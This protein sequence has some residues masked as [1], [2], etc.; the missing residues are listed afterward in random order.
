MQIV[1]LHLHLI[2]FG[3]YPPS[4]SRVITAAASRALF[5]REETESSVTAV[6]YFLNDNLLAKSLSVIAKSPAWLVGGAAYPFGALDEMDKNAIWW[7]GG[8][9]EGGLQFFFFW[10]MRELRS[11]RN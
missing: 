7:G 5:F 2:Q 6:I 3:F 9:V 10:E 1:V 8:G 4:V 11:P